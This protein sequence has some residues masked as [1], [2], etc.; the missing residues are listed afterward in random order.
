L[1]NFFLAGAIILVLAI[2]ALII[3]PMIKPE[4]AE[5]ASGSGWK[6][7][8]QTM[9][10]TGTLLPDGVFKFSMPRSDLNVMIKDVRVMPALALGSWAAFKNV[11]GESMVMGDLVPCQ[12]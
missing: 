5:A 8:E 2:T 11:D 10:R 7:V 3:I 12:G 1:N 4:Q 9:G 6:D